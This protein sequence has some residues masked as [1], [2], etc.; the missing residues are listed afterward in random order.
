MFYKLPLFSD[1]FESAGTKIIK[2]IEPSEAFRKGAKLVF[3]E[4]AIAEIGN[5]SIVSNLQ[6]YGF[7]L[8]QNVQDLFPPKSLAEH[9]DDVMN[10]ITQAYIGLAE[11]QDSMGRQGDFWERPL[12][13][14][15]AWHRDKIT[16]NNIRGIGIL[17]SEQPVNSNGGNF[18][19]IA[20]PIITEPF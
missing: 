5:G 7:A 20:V 2:T 9:T 15:P 14:Y 13:Q 17:G 19:I 12:S 6:K 1:T 3:P 8:I 11:R 18:Q 4:N 10:E 16:P